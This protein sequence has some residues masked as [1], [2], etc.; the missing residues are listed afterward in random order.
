MLF[1]INLKYIFIMNNGKKQLFTI[2]SFNKSHL[3]LFVFCPLM[4]FLNNQISDYMINNKIVSQTQNYFSIYIGYFIINGIILSFNMKNI[5]IFK[6]FS[7]QIKSKKLIIVFILFLILEFLSTYVF[8][9]FSNFPNFHPLFIFLNPIQI[10]PYY[11]FSKYLFNLQMY[12]HHYFSMIIILLALLIN[13]YLG[14]NNLELNFKIIFGSLLLIYIYPFLN[15][16]GYLI[17]Y[18]FGVNLFL[19]LTPLGFVGII[20]G[21]IILIINHIFGINFFKLKYDNLFF[22]EK[23]E[24][25]IIY[26]ILFSILRGVTYILV[27]SLL[28]LFKPWFFEIQNVISSFLLFIYLT[29]KK[30]SENGFESIFILNNIIQI[31]NFIILLFACLIFNEQII[32]NFWGLNK[33]TQNNITTRSLMELI[34]VINNFKV[35][36]DNDHSLNIE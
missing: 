8:T 18:E 4:Y 13:N 27:W 16:L 22:N 14:I 36:D 9:Y 28:S 33:N 30:I 15:M 17:L 32:C 31:I 35:E 26:L 5:Y 19:F 12:K 29:I 24:N 23:G 20:F 11:I 10:I 25:N 21:I 34:D 6:I 7:Y 2:G 3:I 1:N